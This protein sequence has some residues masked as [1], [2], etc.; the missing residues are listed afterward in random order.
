MLKGSLLLVPIAM[1]IICNPNV[2]IF[3][4]KSN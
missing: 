3:N 4:K 1:Y 2:Q